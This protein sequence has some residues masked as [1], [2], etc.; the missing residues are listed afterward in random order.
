MCETV[1]GHKNYETWVTAVW[2]SNEYDEYQKWCRF[3]SK[4]E[5]EAPDAQQVED[6]WW[7]EKEYVKFSLADRMKADY[8]HASPLRD[9]AS[10]FSDLMGA[11]L[12]SVDWEGV[13][14][15]FVEEA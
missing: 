3:A 12:D 11:A 10:L 9:D 1:N 14:S 4:L 6:G 15:Q 2:V 5:D 13:A 8:H 7:T